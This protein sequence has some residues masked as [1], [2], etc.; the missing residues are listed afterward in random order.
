MSIG[1]VFRSSEA[2][3]IL[4]LIK[5]LSEPGEGAQCSC[6]RIEYWIGAFKNLLGLRREVVFIKTP[7][8]KMSVTVG[9]ILF[10]TEVIPEPHVI[11]VVSVV[12]EKRIQLIV[13]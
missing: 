3:Y 4:R 2:Q 12:L 9:T 11:H 6:L 1:N 8:Y 13:I 10:Y 7:A 5:F